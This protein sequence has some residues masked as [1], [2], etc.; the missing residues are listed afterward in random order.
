MHI[1]GDAWKIVRRP[2]EQLLGPGTRGAFDDSG[3]TVGSVVTDGDRLLIYYL[4]WTLSVTVPFRNFIGLAEG[5][6]DSNR[7]TRVS[8]A[9]VLDRS[10]EDPFTLGYPWVLSEETQWRMWYGSHLEWG[11]EG[12]DMRHIIKYASSKDGVN[13]TRNQQVAVGLSAAPEYA[14]S[15]PCVV[16]SGT[17]YQMWYSR[18]APN[19]S[20]GYAESD[21]GVTWTRADDV[22]TFAGPPGEWE[23]D[24]VEYATVFNHAG[25]RYMLYN[26]HGY[27]CTGFGLARLEA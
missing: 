27:G 11:V 25:E 1:S 7:F 2:S 23:S 6:R 21:D 3:V 12:S 10:N 9:P 26:G 14:L 5:R 8:I 22:V 24:T 16:R 19:Y 18:K 4:G 17:K 15:R 13:W 20:L